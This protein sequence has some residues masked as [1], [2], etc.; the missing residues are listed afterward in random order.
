[1]SNILSE[2]YGTPLNSRSIYHCKENGNGSGFFRFGPEIVCY[3]Q[4][5]SGV[6]PDLAGARNFNASGAAKVSNGEIY[7]PFDMSS[8]IDT[9]R[10]EHYVRHLH[11]GHGRFTQ[12]QAVREA[13]YSIRENLPV[14]VRRYLQRAYLRNWRD[15]PFPHWPVDFTVD[16]LHEEYLRLAMLAQGT[17]RI[18]FIWFWPDGASAGL[19]LTHDV[20]TA[21]GRDFTSTLM[22]IDSSYGLKAS[23]QVIPEKRY[24]VSDSYVTEI[25]QRGFEFNIHDLNHDG[26]L[27]DDKDEFLR[28][29]KKIN[30]YAKKYGARGFRAGAMY[31]N[32]DWYDAY[33]FSYD[34]SVPNVAHLE[35]Q[36]GG[37][38]TVMPFFIGKV[39]ELPLTATQDYSIFHILKDD[40]NDLWKR[41]I[42]AIQQRHGLMSFIS[43]PD[44]LIGQ[45]D[46][47][48]YESLL[49]YLRKIVERDAVWAALPGEVD[50]W[51]RSR[52]EMKLVPVGNGYR[53]EGSGSERARIA[54]ANLVG[55]RI[56]Y[57]IE[58]TT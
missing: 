22:D 53:I 9:L 18:P 19:I 46:R 35:P 54:Y 25:K 8:I 32:Q 36:R 2:Y 26:H 5:S 57:S 48:T 58:K 37:C 40:T 1:M 52:H 28:R 39:L 10:L 42:T 16:D 47:A 51:W 3:G 50:Q 30:E 33:E 17:D 12:L 11:F 31:R 56:V 4:C 45:K 49:V 44:Y 13:Y 38:C 55:N 27:Y 43:H 6:A 15:L 14:W 7:L 23:F 24:E 29:A 41:Q 21:V 20:E 34:M